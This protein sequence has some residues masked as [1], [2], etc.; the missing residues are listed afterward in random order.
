MQP[1]IAAIRCFFDSAMWISQFLFDSPVSQRIKAAKTAKLLPLGQ[2]ISFRFRSGQ[3]RSGSGSASPLKSPAHVQQG[4]VRPPPRN[5]SAWLG[6]AQTPAMS[7]LRRGAIFHR[8]F[9]AASLPGRLRP[10]FQQ[11]MWRVPPVPR[12][13]VIAPR[14]RVRTVPTPGHAPGRRSTTCK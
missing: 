14:F 11:Q 10:V 5:A 4:R 7:P 2:E 12:L 6:S 8:D 1:P 13:T 3:S 9:P